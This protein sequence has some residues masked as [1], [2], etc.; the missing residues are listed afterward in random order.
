ML[1]CH[2]L[3]VFQVGIFQTVFKLTRLTIMCF[4]S[5]LYDIHINTSGDANVLERQKCNVCVCVYVC[6]GQT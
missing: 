4:T 5:R 6:V 1:Y 3:F 2:I